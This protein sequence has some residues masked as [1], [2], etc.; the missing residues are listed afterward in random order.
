MSPLHRIATW[1]RPV[2]R[3]HSAIVS[4]KNFDAGRV[5]DWTASSTERTAA[6]SGFSL[7]GTAG[8]G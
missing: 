2:G 5:E 7:S 3:E 4:G 8:G 1:G 6:I